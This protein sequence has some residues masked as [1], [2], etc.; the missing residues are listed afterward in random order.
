MDRVKRK[1]AFE[2]VAFFCS[3]MVVIISASTM[4]GTHSKAQV[5][6][7]IAGSFGAGAALVN[8]IRDHAVKRRKAD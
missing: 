1:L 3:S 8:A 7:L 5:I 2:L 4:A 6:G